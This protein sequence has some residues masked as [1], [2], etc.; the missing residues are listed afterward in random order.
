MKPPAW[1]AALLA[2]CAIAALTSTYEF[3]SRFGEVPGLGLWGNTLTPS[4]QP[5]HFA[6]GS[7]DPGRASD[8]AGLRPGD[9]IDIRA[10]ALLVRFGIFG[11]P[12]SDVPVTLSVRRGALDKQLTVVPLRPDLPRRWDTLFGNPGIVWIAL[13]AALIAWRRSHVPEMRLLC[14]VLVSYAFWRDTGAHSFATPWSWAYIAFVAVNALG[15]LSVAL[16]AACAGCF[17]APLSRARLLAQWVCY[18]LVV[19]SIA[20]LGLRLFGII[21]L[22]IDP[23]ALN[24][25]LARV[26]LD[27]AFLA[28]LA[29]SVLAI[30]QSRGADRQ[31]A[32]WLLVPPAFLFIVMG[33]VDQ[34]E[35][36]SYSNL[37]LTY[38]VYA[39]VVFVTPLVLTYV[40]LSRRL[41][42]VGFVLNRAAVFAIVSTVVIGTFVLVEWA[43]GE[44]F[45]NASHTTSAIIGMI[46]ALALGLSMRY[47]HKYVDRFVDRVFF[48]RRHEDEAAL[49]TFAHEAAYITDRST[50]LERAVQEVRSHTNADEALILVLNGARAYAPAAQTNEKS[51]AVSE[52]DPAIVALRAWHK[53][54]DLNSQTNSGLHG[55]FAFPLVSRGTLVGVLI[56]GPKRDGE[57]YAPDESEALLALAHGVGAALGVLSMQMDDSKI[58]ADELAQ[59]RK[60][61]K[62]DMDLVLREL[63]DLKRTSR[64]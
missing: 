44:W 7:I 37:I 16:W 2:M 21:T 26:P 10:N 32:A 23:V 40:A 46:V 42:D 31:R 51:L 41:M 25:P 6:V 29:C 27:L 20:I 63:A 14:L 36:L 43:A 45:V 47:I 52:N 53:P 13:F 62:R 9:L 59:I 15:P 60:A 28:A 64:A 1:R 54:V 5:F 38:Y 61:I 34:S 55:E 8:R 12:L 58:V 33:A 3:A 30:A 49:R 48:R 18:T 57:A 11:Q 24:S 22:R 50:L 17:A 56:C 4:S 39:F 35:S 19:V